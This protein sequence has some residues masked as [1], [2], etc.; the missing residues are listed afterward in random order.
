MSPECAAFAANR[1]MLGFLLDLA[2]EADPAEA[3]ANVNAMASVAQWEISNAEYETAT[4][5]ADAIVK[6]ADAI[7]KAAYANAEAAV[8]NMEWET[9]KMNT[10]VAKVAWKVHRAA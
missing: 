4:A 1:Y 7:A 10:V 2:T 5:A 3:V 6:A 9:A 8:A